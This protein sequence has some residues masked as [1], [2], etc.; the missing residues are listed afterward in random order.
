MSEEAVESSA[1]HDEPVANLR[2]IDAW[3]NEYSSYHLNAT[4]KLIHWICV[5]LIMVSLLGLLWIIPMPGA[6][7]DVSEW[8]NLAMALFIIAMLFY[9]RLSVP[10]AIGM[11]VIAGGA[12]LGI[13]QMELHNPTIVWKVC[14]LVFIVAWIG[15]FIGHKIEGKKPAFFKDI[16]FLLV[17]PIWLLGFVY[18]RIGIKY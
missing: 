11:A 12:L 10:L 6:V 4:N 5:P 2:P 15:Q 9:L 1:T 16:Q 18:Q 7:S 13:R 14:V 3:L 17:G 8:I